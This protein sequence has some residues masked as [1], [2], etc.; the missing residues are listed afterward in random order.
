ML[1]F[2]QTTAP[3][4]YTATITDNRPA[5][6][7]TFAVA[8]GSLPPGLTM[9]AQSGSG[10]VITGNPTKAGVFNFTIKASVNSATQRYE[11]TITVQGPPDQLLCSSAV[12]GGFL[13]SGV[14]VL[15]DAVLGQPYQ[16]TCPPA[17]TPAAR[18]A[19]SPGRS[20]QA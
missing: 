12:N 1:P 11:I 4:N 7:P 13:E 2:G 5:D 20:P 6:A 17:I 14:C 9:P 3:N 18:S 10:T 15:P 8:A 16:G 19:L